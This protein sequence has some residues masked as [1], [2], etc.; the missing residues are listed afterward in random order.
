MAL[1][2]HEFLCR[3]CGERFEFLAQGEA[4]IAQTMR[5]CDYC[6]GVADRVISA[7]GL[8]VINRKNSDFFVRNKPRMRARSRDHW[9]RKGRAEAVDRDREQL[10]KYVAPA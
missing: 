3:S 10:K 4:E 9:M 8:Q 5:P 7:P 6:E 1:R 2:M